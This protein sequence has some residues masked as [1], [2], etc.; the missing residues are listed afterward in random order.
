M[1]CPLF[2]HNDTVAQLAGA[3]QRCI[4]ALCYVTEDEQMISRGHVERWRGEA[5]E[6]EREK[7]GREWLE[8][9]GGGGDSWQPEPMRAK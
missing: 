2:P 8:D 1:P 3:G 7:R 9:E 5:R 6:R 4:I